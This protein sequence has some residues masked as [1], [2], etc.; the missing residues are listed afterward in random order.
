MVVMKHF[1]SSRQGGT[2]VSRKQPS[3]GPRQPDN[4]PVVCRVAS[5]EG[6]L[7]AL[8]ISCGSHISGAYTRPFFSST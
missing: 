5:S 2:V 4:T 3:D 8:S 6:W 1:L 7:K